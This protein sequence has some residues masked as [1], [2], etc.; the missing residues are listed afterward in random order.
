M[1]GRSKKDG[2]RIGSGRRKRVEEEEL[3][4]KLNP[5]EPEAFKQLKNALQ[6]RQRW[7]VELFFAYRYGKPRQMIETS[8]SEGSPCNF[9]VTIADGCRAPVTSEDDIDEDIEP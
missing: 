9:T 6:D 7:A 4:A 3:D 2:A 5:L 1:A 8:G